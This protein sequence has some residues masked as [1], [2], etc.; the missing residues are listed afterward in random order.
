[1]QKRQP[2]Q[3]TCRSCRCVD[4]FDFHVPDLVWKQVVPKNLQTRVVCLECFDKFAAEKQV[5]Y[6]HFLHTVY[7]AGEKA[8]M[9]LKVVD[10]HDP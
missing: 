1:M 3:Q 7:F 6:T 2:S 5:P 9:E 8:Q 4:K 10:S